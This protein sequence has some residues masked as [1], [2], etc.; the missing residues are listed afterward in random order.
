[1]FLRVFSP[2]ATRRS[3][4][5]SGDYADLSSDLCGTSTIVGI[6][7]S[8]SYQCVF[9]TTSGPQLVATVARARTPITSSSC[10][11]S[12]AFPPSTSGSNVRATAPI[13]RYPPEYF[14]FGAAGFHHV[15]TVLNDLALAASSIQAAPPPAKRRRGAPSP[16]SSMRDSRGHSTWKALIDSI[17]SPSKER[18]TATY[19]G[20]CD[21]T[22]VGEWSTRRKHQF[23][24]THARHLE[25]EDLQ[26]IPI[27]LCPACPEDLGCKDEGQRVDIYGQKGR[28]FDTCA[29]YRALCKRTNTKPE[30]ISTNRAAVKALLEE[31][32]RLRVAL[33]F[34]TP[35]NVPSTF[36]ITPL[37]LLTPVTHALPSDGACDPSPVEQQH[38]PSG[39][40]Q[41]SSTS[42]PSLTLSPY[43]STPSSRTLTPIEHTDI[44]NS[45]SSPLIPN[46]SP[47]PIDW[48]TQGDSR[49]TNVPLSTYLP[50]NRARV[51]ERNSML[52]PATYMRPDTL[53]ANE[54]SANWNPMAANSAPGRR[55]VTEQGVLATNASEDF[56]L[57]TGILQEE[58]TVN[59]EQPVQVKGCGPFLSSGKGPLDLPSS[60]PFSMHAAEQRVSNL[61]PESY[62]FISPVSKQR[63]SASD[64]W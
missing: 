59:N 33:G 58:F 51:S 1:M 55:Q 36:P 25:D 2:R 26:Y 7:F 50:P 37:P 38:S 45:C 54:L 4:R 61:P 48:T 46:P 64:K 24:A 12:D 62:G 40:S 49:G 32:D 18:I 29:A 21:G 23:S 19:P 10:D 20:C 31:R 41:S 15:S 11:M 39:S 17:P 30:P 16:H 63:K 34:R 22:N 3:Q 43:S 14:A 44:Q 5:P 27:G 35:K 9:V 56:N 57:H 28:H 60:G 8:T 6:Y 52:N 13:V 53:S 47:A 42:A